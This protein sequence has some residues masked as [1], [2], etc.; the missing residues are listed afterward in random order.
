MVEQLDIFTATPVK[1]PDYGSNSDW[2]NSHL[3]EV[4]NC[5]CCGRWNKTYR[6]TITAAMAHALILI[7]RYYL[8][9]TYDSWLQLEGYFK[10]CNIGSTIRGDVPKLRFWGL[11]EKA[12]C[13]ING[14]NGHYRLTPKGQRFVKGD[15]LVPRYAKIYNDQFFGFDGEMIGI[16]DCIENYDPVSSVIAE[17]PHV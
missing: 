1:K 9:H 5:P 8:S 10:R 6:R 14:R 11:I 13:S 12:P 4:F 17:I 16:S 7:Y 3:D 2:V 15:E